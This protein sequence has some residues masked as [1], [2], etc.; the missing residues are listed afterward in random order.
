MLD[1]V[2]DLAYGDSQSKMKTFRIFRIFRMFRVLRVM[3][4]L[5]R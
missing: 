3:R 4:V 2:A 5:Y 1:M